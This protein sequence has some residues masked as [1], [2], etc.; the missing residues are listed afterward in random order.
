MEIINYPEQCILSELNLPKGELQRCI[1]GW[2]GLNAVLRDHTNMK[3]V[4]LK[5]GMLPYLEIHK[6]RLPGEPFL[7][8]SIQFPQ[9]RSEEA[10]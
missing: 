10:L 4:L 3:P 5:F 2:V 9:A 7:D 1:E 8:D 6:P